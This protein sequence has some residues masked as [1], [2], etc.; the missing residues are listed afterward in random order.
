M[1]TAATAAEPSEPIS[2]HETVTH[3]VSSATQPE[4]AP[5]VAE[6][7]PLHVEPVAEVA[8]PTV[9]AEPEI[10]HEPA[11]VEVH[12]VEERPAPQPAHEHRPTVVEA[13]QSASHRPRTAPQQ[14]ALPPELVQVETSSAPPAQAESETEDS[15]Q[16]RRPRRPRP[17][18]TAQESEPLVQVE[19]RSG[20]NP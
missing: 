1:A 2:R 19:T 14:Y 11:P 12:R 18:E 20:S 10:R 16:A 5:A 15:Q 3:E 9:H 6:A 8:A 13:M 7:R 17:A 4:I